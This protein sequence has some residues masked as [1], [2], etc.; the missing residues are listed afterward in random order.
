MIKEFKE[1]A[2]RGN[3]VDMA[4]GIIIGG[5]FGTIVKSLVD[6]VLMPPI[7]LLLGGVDFANFFIVLRQGAKA[8]APYAALADAKA[9]GAVTINYG[10][11][12][13]SII[14]FLIVAF[15]VFMLVRSI[16]RLRRKEEPEAVEPA[17]RECPYCMSAIAVKASRCPHCTSELK[18]A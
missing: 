1:F 3:V 16:N 18:P 4:V 12:L 2:V 17:I 14:S 5:A 13:N 7:G 15:A 11:F 8:A 6:D 9:A 10:L